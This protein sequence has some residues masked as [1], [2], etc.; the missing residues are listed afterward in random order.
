M[1]HMLIQTHLLHSEPPKIPDGLCGVQR[2]EVLTLV[3]QLCERET[4]A[5]NKAGIYRDK[6]TQ[7]KQRCRE[8][9]EEKEGVR[10]FWRNKVIEGQSRAGMLVKLAISGHRAS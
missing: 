6:C 5:T 9:E 3:K 2:V 4:K 10:F 8:L 7:L 1:G